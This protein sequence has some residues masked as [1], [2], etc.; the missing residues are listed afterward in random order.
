[1]PEVVSERNSLRKVFI[2]R[3]RPR[4]SSCDL[5]HLTGM[6]EPCPVVISRR[7]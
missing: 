2:E 1:M 7:G 3:Q 6:G 4:Y 5:R